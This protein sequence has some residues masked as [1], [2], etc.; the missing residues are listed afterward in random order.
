MPLN[1]PDSYPDVLAQV[2]H[3]WSLVNEARGG[4]P[5]TDLTLTGGY[6]RADMEADHAAMVSALR[7][8][9]DAERERRIASAIRDERR[10]AVRELHIRF[11]AAVR[12]ALPGHPAVA[13]VMVTPGHTASRDATMGALNIMRTAWTRANTL[14]PSPEFAPPLLLGATTL[15]D[16]STELAALE[17]SFAAVQSADEE[18]RVARA[19]RD[20]LLRRVRERLFQYKNAVVAAL[21]PRHTLM[22]SVPRLTP[23]RGSTPDPVVVTAVW[24][25]ALGKAVL[26]WE[27]SDNPNVEAYSIR[28]APG[29]K[30]RVREEQVIG[31]VGKDVTRFETL[32]G[33]AAPGAS[34]LFRVVVVLKTGHEKGS[35]VVRVARD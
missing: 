20:L 21:G 13:A 3:H 14:P 24:D 8:A 16:F 11:R 23:R 26:T 2:L 4:T 17:D 27:P 30:Y 28:T 34:A 9:R 15:A 18:A 22:G 32:T 25:A 19:E 10:E 5:A 1:G 12:A 29:P 33:M 31:R 6:T 7:K 35:E